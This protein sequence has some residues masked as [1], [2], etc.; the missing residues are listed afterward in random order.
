[1]CRRQ[2]PEGT[3][4]SSLRSDV[5]PRAAASQGGAHISRGSS[6]WSFPR[7]TGAEGRELRQSG[8]GAR[9]E[10]G[11]EA[12]AE[13]TGGGACPPSLGLGN[14][15]RQHRLRRAKSRR[16]LSGDARSETL[17]LH[18]AGPGGAEPTGDGAGV[19][20]EWRRAGSRAGFSAL[21]RGRGGAR[22]QTESASRQCYDAWAGGGA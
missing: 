10:S 6:T 22:V 11:G 13:P 5:S 9:P 14:T 19:G 21:G 1:M 18:G 3:V 20:S 15:R 2:D 12:G 16:D 7:W 17:G 4:V 8:A